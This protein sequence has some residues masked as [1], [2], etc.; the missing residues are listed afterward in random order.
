MLS[1][2]KVNNCHDDIFTEP[3]I[4]GLVQSHFDYCSVVW[5]NCAK[6]LP[7]KLQRLQNRAVFVLTN[8]CYDAD[9]NQLVKE[10]EPLRGT[11]RDPVGHGIA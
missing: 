7:D 6:I 5:G 2:Q 10:L 8:T 9:A 4:G 1:Q 3:Y 11:Y